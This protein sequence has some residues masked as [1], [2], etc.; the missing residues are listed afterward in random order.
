LA[1][2]KV[3]DRQKVDSIDLTSEVTGMLPVANGG[4]GA[5]TLTGLV[6]GTGTTAMVAASAGTDYVAPSGSLGTPS[7][8]NLTNCTNYPI[9]FL[10]PCDIMTTGQETYTIA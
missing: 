8:G 1:V 10:A 9:G 4:T 5:G 7:S 2:T 3:T 6:K